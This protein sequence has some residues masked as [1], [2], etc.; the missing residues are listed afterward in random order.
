MSELAA[1]PTLTS[2]LAQPVRRQ[3]DQLAVIEPGTGQPRTLTYREL[4]LSARYLAGQLR[5]LG[6]SRGDVIAVW[7]P[8]CLEWFAVEFAAARIGAVVLGVNTRYRTHELTHL[9]RT[10]RPVCVL[11]PGRFLG[12]DFAEVLRQAA[13]SLRSGARPGAE[14]WQP[15]VVA[16]AGEAGDDAAW[17]IGGGV[18][19]LD[20]LRREGSTGDEAADG[21]APD[22]VNLFTT[23]GSTSAPKLAGHDQASVALHSVHVARA[24]GLREND[25]LTCILPLCGVFG[26]NG[27]LAALAAG[28]VCLVEPAFHPV[29][30]VAHMSEYGMTHLNGGDDLYLR[31]IEAYQEHPADLSRW[32]RGGIAN[33]TGKAEFAIRWVEEHIGAEIAGVYGSSE[34]FALMATWPQ[35]LPTADRLRGGGRVVA[36]AAEVRV[37]GENGGQGLPPGE[38]G[39]LQFRG[40]NVLHEYYGNPD[41]TAAAFTV[42]GWFRSGDLGYLQD[43]SSF[44]YLCRSGDALRLHGFLVE[45]VEIENFLMTHPAVHTARLVGVT[46]PEHGD[47]AVAFVTLRSGSGASPDQLTAFCHQ[48]LASYKVPSRI[49]RIDEFPVTLGTNG[50]KILTG[51]LREMA[52]RHLSDDAGSA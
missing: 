24:F 37:A 21:Q 3:P 14:P 10:A 8:N 52:V 22:L 28:A 42:D 18:V 47:I 16:L 33:F 46:L 12:I 20:V 23:S 38:P 1:P 5:S 32:R 30:A 29:S 4:D 48:G 49:I 7:L 40:Y 25:R 34:C 41:A 11:A 50:P 36:Q 13:G 44:V 27:A 9:L 39:E 17:D 6:V 31:L 43:S 51:K 15:P 19:S 45:P 2:L 35:G 26:F